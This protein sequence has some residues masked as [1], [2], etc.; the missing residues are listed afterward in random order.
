MIINRC[1]IFVTTCWGCLFRLPGKRFFII[2]FVIVFFLDHTA[3]IPGRILR[4]LWEK[5]RFRFLLSDN[6]G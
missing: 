4:F 3:R 2:C 5:Y 6:S 1:H